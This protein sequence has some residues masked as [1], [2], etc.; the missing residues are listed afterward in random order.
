MHAPYLKVGDTIAIVATARHVDEK[1][2]L[3]A[4][5]TFE[6]WGL[7]VVLSDRIYEKDNAL[8]GN[9]E[10]RAQAFQNLLDDEGSLILAREIVQKIEAEMS[11]PGQIKV[12]VIREKRAIEYAK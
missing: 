1:I 12:N 5:R 11:F 2:I 7:K 9:D 6:S 8:A 4:V 10:T 3:P